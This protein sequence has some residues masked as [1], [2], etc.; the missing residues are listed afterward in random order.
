VDYSDWLSNLRSGDLVKLVFT[1]LDHN[2]FSRTNIKESS[3]SFVSVVS[4]CGRKIRFSRRTGLELNP[5]GRTR[6][7]LPYN[8]KVKKNDV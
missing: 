2:I 4:S 6:Q 7:I 8:K 5:V 3:D 1:D